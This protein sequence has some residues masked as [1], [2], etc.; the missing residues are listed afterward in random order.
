MKYILIVF[1]ITFCGCI[2]TSV[3]KIES[4]KEEIRI[5]YQYFSIHR[6]S[7]DGHEYILFDDEFRKAAMVHNPEC[8]CLRVE[9]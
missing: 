3:K 9:E 8:P 7:L 2:D 5:G 4:T 1:I 6:F